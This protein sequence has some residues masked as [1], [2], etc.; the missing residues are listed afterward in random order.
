MKQTYESV[1]GSKYA[2]PE[3]PVYVIATN[4]DQALLI[5]CFNCAEAAMVEWYLKSVLNSADVFPI[6][7]KSFPKRQGPFLLAPGIVRDAA[8][9]VKKKGVSK[10]S[11]KASGRAVVYLIS[12]TAR[13]ILTPLHLKTNRDIVRE[14]LRKGT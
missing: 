9:W 13:R 10:Y 11:S 8:E 6:K 1:D 12:G 7:A 3:T 2:L 5:P 14:Q 4:K